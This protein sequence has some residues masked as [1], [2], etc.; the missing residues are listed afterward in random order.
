MTNNATR[1]FTYQNADASLGGPPFAAPRTSPIVADRAEDTRRPWERS[2][3]NY[4]RQRTSR[5]S[6]R[7]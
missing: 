4:R 5:F 6:F 2:I 1:R 7:V 3:Q